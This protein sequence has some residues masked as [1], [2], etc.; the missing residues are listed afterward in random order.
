MTR[1]LLTADTDDK[2]RI[3]FCNV[4]IECDITACTAPHHQLSEIRPGRPTDQRIAFQ[5]IDSP[6]DVSNMR[7]RI[8][9]LMR[10]EM[11]QDAIEIIPDLWRELDARHT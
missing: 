11:S 10:N 1:F 7:W 9:R 2:H 4:S 5:H 8:R 6:Y 3:K